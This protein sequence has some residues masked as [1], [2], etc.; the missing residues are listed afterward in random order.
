MEIRPVGATEYMRTVVPR[1]TGQKRRHR[2]LPSCAWAPRHAHTYMRVLLLPLRGWSARGAPLGRSQ[3]M[4]KPSV[5]TM[6]LSSCSLSLA[7]ALYSGSSRWLKHVCAEGS[8]AS[9]V[10]AARARARARHAP[11][12]QR[13]NARRTARAC[14]AR[15]RTARAHGPRVGAA[16]RARVCGTLVWACRCAR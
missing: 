1:C 16:R 9:S 11:R 12:G 13:H 14:T 7:L 10:P 5:S 3:I 8:R 2:A 15:A 6:A 4:W